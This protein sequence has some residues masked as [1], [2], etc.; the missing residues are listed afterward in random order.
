MRSLMLAAVCGLVAFTPAAFA[1][2]APA[3]PAAPEAG[4]AI[5]ETTPLELTI[6]GTAKYTLDLG[7]ATAEEFEKSL[8]GDKTPA[9]PKV[10]LKLVIKN[11][12]KET[13]QLWTSGDSVK[14]DLTLTGKGAAK[15]TPMLATTADFRL[16]KAVEIEAGKT[17]ELPI[18][19]LAGGPRGIGEYAYWMQAGDYELVATLTSAVNPA[20]KGAADAGDGFGSV[21]AAS[22]AFKVTVSEKK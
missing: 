12:S 11:T 3:K 17:V 14:V 10:E 19:A 21:Q 15:A 1:K 5:P 22:K 20:P 9:P 18:K 2:R 8:K 4:K 16:P 7:G 6:E 13:V